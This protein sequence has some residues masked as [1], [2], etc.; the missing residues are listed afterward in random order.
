M[1]D[2]LER[3]MDLVITL[4]ETERLIGSE[5][6]R[7]RVPGY[8]DKLE[9]FRRTFERDKEEL[10][11]LGIPLTMDYIP[12]S[13]PPTLGYR[14]LKSEFYLSD[15][16]LEPDELEALHLATT[17]VEL[18][19][20]SGDDALWT[21]GGVPGPKPDAA[22]DIEIPGDP[23]LGS[24][25]GAIQARGTLS[26]PYAENDRVVDPYRLDFRNGYWYLSGRDHERDAIR[27]FRVDRIEGPI[28]VGEPGAFEHPGA[29]GPVMLIPWEIGEGDPVSARLSVDPHRAGHAI[30]ILG[31]EKIVE[32]LE[33]G[34]VVFEVPV[35]NRE[36]FRSFVLGFLEHAELL[37]PESM[38]RDLRA[39]LTEIAGRG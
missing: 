8:P 9:S 22:I 3:L 19:G 17:I 14:I 6:L 20:T 16:G 4:L 11:E 37:G 29:Q 13:D 5:E 2:K 23:D 34:S 31:E 28:D 25:F 32:R 12:G 24:I 10:R 30:M 33:D 35:V 18:A 26:F 7:S 15:P 1:V 36:A 21:L 27:T 38:R 39:W